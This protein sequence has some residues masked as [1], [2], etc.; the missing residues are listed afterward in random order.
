MSRGHRENKRSATLTVVTIHSPGLF[1]VACAA[2][3]YN[4][5]RG[6]SSSTGSKILSSAPHCFFLSFVASH[7][8]AHTQTAKLAEF[9]SSLEGRGS[10]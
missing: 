8:T 2:Q 6:P 1:M 3:D 5:L 10:F 7:S 4:K 9:F